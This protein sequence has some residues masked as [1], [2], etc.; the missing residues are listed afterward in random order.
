LTEVNNN[1]P[2]NTAAH[3]TDNTVAAPPLTE[4]ESESEEEAEQK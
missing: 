3:P 1:L 2:T 4:S